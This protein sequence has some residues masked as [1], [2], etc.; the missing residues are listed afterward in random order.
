M[1]NEFDVIEKKL[2]DLFKA[3]SNTEISKGMAIISEYFEILSEN[4]HCSNFKDLGFTIPLALIKKI[5]SVNL[6]L[7]EKTNAYPNSVKNQ[8]VNI[9]KENKI[10]DVF[11]K[12]SNHTEEY[13]KPEN[14]QKLKHPFEKFITLADK[15]VDFI[16]SYDIYNVKI[17]LKR[18]SSITNYASCLD[19]YDDFEEFEDLKHLYNPTLIDRQKIIALINIL[20]VVIDPLPP[21]DSEQII[22]KLDKLEIEIKKNKPSWKKLITG[23]FII[24]GVLANFK[25]IAPETYDT[26]LHIVSLIFTEGQVSKEK[27]VNNETKE[28]PFKEV[29]KTYLNET[30]A[31]PED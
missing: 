21:K 29:N 2:S 3:S 7:V 28:I 30:K 23:F 16:S 19:I 18:L 24:V 22:R 4:I 12:L 5:E 11:T 31:K 10:V 26:A 13:L 1:I 14:F 8:V 27:N 20:R 6:W 9:F 25:T 15:K 17:A